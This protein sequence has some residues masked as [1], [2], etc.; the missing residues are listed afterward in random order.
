MRSGSRVVLATALAVMVAVA[1]GCKKSS[2]Q[3]Q[4]SGGAGPAVAPDDDSAPSVT[5]V[6]AYS[7][8]KKAWMQAEIAAFLATKP[9]LPSGKRIAIDAKSLGSGEAAT[10][11]L[12]GSLKA[13][14]YSPASTAYLTV[15]NHGW[16]SNA[17]TPRTK[18]LAPTSE[19]LVL[20]PI[21]IAMWKPMAEALGWPAKDLGWA[22]IIKISKDPAGWGALG[23]PEWGAFKLGHTHP[24]FSNSGLLAVLAEAYAGAKKTRGLDRADLDSATTKAFIADVEQAIVHYGQ[25]TSL[26]TDKMLER[27][28]G[29]MSAA[30]SYENLVVES[31]SK[32]GAPFPLV[33]IYPVEGTFW[34]DH[35]YAIL[36]AEWVGADEKAAA[37]AFL[38]H[39]KSRPAQERALALGFRPA[40]P[41]VPIGAPLTAD[42]GV[43]ASQPQTLL[44][45]PGALVLDQLLTVWRAAKKPAQVTL[46]FDR[47]GSMQGEPLTAAKA[48]AG[49]FL[50]ALGDRDEVSIVF[51]ND[52]VPPVPAPVALAKARPALHQAVDATFADGGTALYDAT[53]AA[54]AS[55][56]SA[57]KRDHSRI[58][59]VVV[60]TD[61]KDEH[62]K[63]SLDALRAKFSA[64]TSPVKIFTIAYGDNADPTVL[65]RIAA[66]G[67]GTSVVGSSATIVQVYRDLSTFF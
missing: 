13:H 66:D 31:Y 59:A 5:L 11:I 65:E 9:K 63:M 1:A 4:A 61:G 18:P 25:S 55:M 6:V 42:H 21:V 20:S 3:G 56:L 2:D 7:S 36:D 27:G 30:V 38:A 35:P 53:A 51:F 15:L 43:D 50:D 44:E 10:A 58:Y 14:V 39:L 23:H 45:V 33:A 48:G 37:Q 24:E 16:M 47:S 52:D 64:E 57:A 26:F 41:A 32:S 17:A 8:E 49:A 60:M 34:S 67:Q 19:P 54:Y 62:S 22:D 40:D 29:Y 12:D 28:P 46:V